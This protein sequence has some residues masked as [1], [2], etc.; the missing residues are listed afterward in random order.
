MSA[1]KKLAGQTALYGISHVTGRLINYLLVPFYT[2]FFILKDYGVISEVYAYMA[3]L[4]VLLTYGMETGL[5]RFQNRSDINGPVYSTVLYTI[6][7]ST[8]LF[9]VL[10]LGFNHSI[11]GFMGYSNHPEYI[12]WFIWIVALDV[13]AA[14]PMARLRLDN[15][16]VYFLVV[17]LASIGLNIA[18]N[19]FFFLYC[20]DIFNG[21]HADQHI[22]VK[23]LYNPAIGLG[24]VF[25]ANLCASLF[26]V[27]LL[28]PKFTDTASRWDYALFRK[29]LGYSLP[30]LLLGFAGIINETFDRVMLTRLLPLPHDQ[31]LAQLGIYNACYKVAMLLSIGIQA[32]RYAA[33]PFIFSNAEKKDALHQQAEIMR[34]YVAVAVGIALA[35]FVFEDVALH[36]IGRAYREGRGIIPILLL[37]YVCYGV[38]FN[39]SF[40][41]KLTDRTRFGAL[42]S[43]FGAGITVVLNFWLVPIIGYMGAAWATLAAYF[44]MML[45]SYF[46]GKYYS[47]MAYDLKTI[48]GYFGIAVGCAVIW[49]FVPKGIPPTLHWTIGAILLAAY[50]LFLVAIEKRKKT[51]LNHV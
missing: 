47:P 41:Y 7:G 29:I 26:K 46:L 5:F 15:R 12:R 10:A 48:S 11:A 38:V 33:E 44:G 2:R 22:L 23:W 3:F 1:L 28:L 18:L 4:L 20:R 6:I 45:I 49:E 8:T 14:I 42:I 36:I 43:I 17:N 19:L 9:L 40:W 35:I 51:L 25:I 34:Y 37:A 31:A 24:Y 13:L 32:F 50:A 21:G 16:P 27:I 30:L 39:L